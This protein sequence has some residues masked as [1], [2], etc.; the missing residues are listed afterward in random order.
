MHE[1]DEEVFHLLEE[2]LYWHLLWLLQH[3]AVIDML[4]LCGVIVELVKQV[5]S[6]TI[7]KGLV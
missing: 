5:K 1:I 2:I 7:L 3:I 6:H 4:M